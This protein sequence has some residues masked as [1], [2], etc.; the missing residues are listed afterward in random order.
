MNN[1]NH[2]I[3]CKKNFNQELVYIHY[4]EADGF[5][6]KPKNQLK[7]NGIKVNEMVVINSSFIEKVLKRKI[8]RKLDS[9]LQFLIQLLDEG[10]ED[11]TSLRHALTDLDRYRRTI[12]N[13]YRN[14]LD[15]KYIDLL[16]KKL[17]VLER[18]LKNKLFLCISKQPIE[19][20]YENERRRGR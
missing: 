6:F 2:Y 12:L 18:E 15:K 11:P 5:K 7:Y 10:T 14:Y 8:K 4:S 19:E 13:K 1:K 17:D 9:Y 16:L 20:E 3:L